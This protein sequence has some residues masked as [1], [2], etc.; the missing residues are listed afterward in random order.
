MLQLYSSSSEEEEKF[1]KIE[2]C[3]SPV[4][5]QILIPAFWIRGYITFFTNEEAKS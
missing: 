1:D 3:L 4:N 2:T 5:T